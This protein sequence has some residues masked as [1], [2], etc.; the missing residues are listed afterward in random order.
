MHDCP[1]QSLYIYQ[2]TNTAY[3][4]TNAAGSS[5]NYYSWFTHISCFY[6]WSE[7]S[8]PANSEAWLQVPEGRNRLEEAI[9]ISMNIYRC[10]HWRI[11]VWRCTWY[12]FFPLVYIAVWLLEAC[13]VDLWGWWGESQGR[14][15][16]K[17][18]GMPAVWTCRKVTI[19]ASPHR[20][21]W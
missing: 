3:Q 7:H 20:K 18:G 2:E 19:G 16:Q 4:E 13:M 15:F 6:W 17:G 8:I 14:G 21:I 11:N 9:T 12:T 1:V 5:N 10:M